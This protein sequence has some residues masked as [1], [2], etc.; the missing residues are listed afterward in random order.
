MLK[1]FKNYLTK[2]VAMLL[3]T[4]A[5]QAFTALDANAQGGGGFQALLKTLWDL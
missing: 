3:L 5:F 4:P 1:L 2:S